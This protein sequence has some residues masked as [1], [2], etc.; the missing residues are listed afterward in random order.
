MH[1]IARPRCP[2]AHPEPGP[3]LGSTGWY[4]TRGC[5]NDEPFYA[6]AEPRELVGGAGFEPAP[7]SV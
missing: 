4:C 3:T 7:S 2:N 1:L 6:C 5:H